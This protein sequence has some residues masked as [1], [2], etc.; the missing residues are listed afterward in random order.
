MGEFFDPVI[1]ERWHNPADR[2]HKTFVVLAWLDKIEYSRHP[3]G[4][5]PERFRLPKVSLSENYRALSP[6]RLRADAR[7]AIVTIR[8]SGGGDR[9]RAVRGIYSPASSFRARLLLHCWPWR[10][11]RTGRAVLPLLCVLAALVF[12]GIARAV[13]QP[14]VSTPALSVPDNTTAI[15]E[16]CVVDP[17]LLAVGPRTLYH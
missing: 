12:G 1:S 5:C 8:F 6:L 14:T 16:G 3:S 9:D 15:F 2:A 11:G 17:A 13:S 10:H 4:Y 7:A